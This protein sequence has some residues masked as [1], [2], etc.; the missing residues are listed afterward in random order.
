[1]KPFDSL[2]WL[3][4]YAKSK[5]YNGANYLFFEKVVYISNVSNIFIHLFRLSNAV[6]N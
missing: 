4:K 5:G 3:T 2:N 1:M 6:A